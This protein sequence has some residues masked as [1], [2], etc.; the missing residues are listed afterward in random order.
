MPALP[1]RPV[2]LL[3]CCLLL[4]CIALPA[5]AAAQTEPLFR[6]VDLAIGESTEVELPGGKRVTVELRDARPSR[7]A[8][9][10]A[11]RSVE[12]DVVVDGKPLTLVSGLY[13][14]PV[15]VAGVQIDCPVTGHY[16]ADSHI[17]HWGIV[18]DARLRIWLKD[19]PWI[20]PGTFVY[21]VGQ[22]WFASQTW[23]SNEAVSARPDGRFYYH[24]GM[25]IGGSEGQVP[26]YAATDGEVVSV[27]NHS[28]DGL[29]STAVQ[30]R[31][32]VIYLKDE[33]GW[34]YRYSHLDSIRTFVRL[35]HRVKA[36][37]Q[38]GTIGKEGASGGWSHLHFEIKSLQPSGQWGTQ[39]AY[40]FLWQAYR[41]QFDRQIVAHARPRYL[42]APGES[43]VLDGT[44]S[45]ASGKI[46]RY[47]WTFTDGTTATGPRVERV[48]ARPGSYSEILE[49]TDEKGHRDV[50]FAIVKVM[51]PGDP[52]GVPGM[53]PTYFPTRDLQPGTPITFKV[54]ARNTTEG[55]D[56]WDFGDGSPPVA[57]QSNTDPSGHAP[58]GYAATVHR[59]RTPG[60][61]V[62]SVRRSTPTGDAIA[63]LYVVI[64]QEQTSP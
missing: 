31:Y 27:A 53:H 62:V 17:D 47:A 28:I 15:P 34:Y 6:T 20:R 63:H 46:A 39:D 58:D 56:I 50:D 13:R 44:R 45:W 38:L 4:A 21:P 29:P 64:E 49:V 18:K 11:I 54:R 19:S 23:F 37:D 33:R 10:K 2:P 41:D 26:V 61:Y 1:R 22:K 40:A 30:P 36:G 59:Y 35:G 52:T 12:I 16:N 60:R 8:V 25:D 3:P 57:V 48:Y 5:A 42:L 43:V 24:S 14:L 55:T 9:M 51:Q 7:D 32:D